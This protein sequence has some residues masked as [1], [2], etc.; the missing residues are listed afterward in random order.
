MRPVS[1]RIRIKLVRLRYYP[2]HS[3]FRKTDLL[4]DPSTGWGIWMHRKSTRHW[5]SGRP[6][7]KI[8]LLALLFRFLLSSWCLSSEVLNGFLVSTTEHHWLITLFYHAHVTFGTEQ[9]ASNSN[10]YRTVWSSPV[11]CPPCSTTVDACIFALVITTY[12][13]SIALCFRLASCFWQDLLWSARQSNMSKG[14]CKY[15]YAVENSLKENLCISLLVADIFP[16]VFWLLAHSK[17]SLKVLLADRVFQP[18]FWPNGIFRELLTRGMDRTGRPDL[19]GYQKPSLVWIWA[20]HPE[21]S[22]SF[23]FLTC[24]S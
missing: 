13:N 1:C 9:S 17:A 15:F 7:V 8:H 5:S 21:K 16:F 18:T 3:G 22:T 14:R 20:C 19:V 24:P 6:G 4:N 10:V 11:A 12:N 2:S 23:I